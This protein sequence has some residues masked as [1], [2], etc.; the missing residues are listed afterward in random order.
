[1][2]K[3]SIA[4]WVTNI[5]I[6][7]MQGILPLMTMNAT[8]TKQGMLHLGYPVY[9][10]SM[11]AFFKVAGATALLIP[12]IPGRIKEWA[13]AGFAIDFVCAFISIVIT[14]GFSGVAFAPV[15]A[16]AILIISYISFHKIRE[17]KPVIKVFNT[18]P[19]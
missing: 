17:A 13:Y 4:L 19:A 15:V 1:M 11:L 16:L 8:E 2:K 3:Y 18:N 6:F 10:G 14:D 7:I 9:F 5:I 12:Q